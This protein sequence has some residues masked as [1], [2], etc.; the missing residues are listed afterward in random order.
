MCEKIGEDEC[1][2]TYKHGQRQSVDD[3]CRASS[4]GFN[5]RSSNVDKWNLK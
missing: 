3:V 1:E 2:E 4:V 5:Y